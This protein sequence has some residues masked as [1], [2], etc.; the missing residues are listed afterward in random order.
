MNMCK[1]W[2]G[3]LKFCILVSLPRF[4][5]LQV[6]MSIGSIKGRGG[7]RGEWCAGNHVTMTNG[8]AITEEIRV[9]SA[10]KLTRLEEAVPEGLTDIGTGKPRPYRPPVPCAEAF[11][12]SNPIS[13]VKGPTP[14][15]EPFVAKQSRHPSDPS[16]PHRRRSTTIVHLFHLPSPS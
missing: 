1:N 14:K 4:D 5:D 12:R 13:F 16:T 6:P 2:I 15:R 10:A 11:L 8:P 3:V 7:M 9:T